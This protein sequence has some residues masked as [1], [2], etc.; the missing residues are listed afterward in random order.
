MNDTGAPLD[1]GEPVT[2]ARGCVRWSWL[3]SGRTA[4]DGGM[5]SMRLTGILAFILPVQVAYDWLTLFLS[6]VA[7]IL[8]SF[9]VLFVGNRKKMGLLPM[10]AGPMYTSRLVSRREP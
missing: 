8:V 6:L 2:A 10:L 5:R 1:F 4:L 7:A 3:V 9:V